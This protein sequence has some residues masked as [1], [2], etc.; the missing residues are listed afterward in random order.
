[1]ID[2]N[3]LIALTAALNRE[4]AEYILFG[5][6]AVNLHGLRRMTEDFDFFVNPSPENVRRIKRALRSL[7]D[8]P[9]LEEIQDDDMVGDYPN[10]SYAPPGEGF[11]LD[12]VSRLGEVFRYEDLEAEVHDVEGVAIRIATPRTLYRM[13][14]NTVRPMD[15]HDAERLREKFRL[16]ED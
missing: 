14:R 15:R 12:F 8:D 13:K 10:F 4:E 5:G 1:M 9:A 7:W 11:G 2:F 16:S 3:K 6:A